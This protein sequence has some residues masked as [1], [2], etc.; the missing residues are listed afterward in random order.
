MEKERSGWKVSWQW[1]E[2]PP[3]HT[4]LL[5]HVRQHQKTYLIP[6]LI[7]VSCRF[8][9]DKRMWQ[10]IASYRLADR[11]T[12]LVQDSIIT[13]FDTVVCNS[14]RHPQ[15]TWAVNVAL[16]QH[17]PQRC[18]SL[19]AEQFFKWQDWSSDKTF[20]ESKGITSFRCKA[21]EARRSCY[22]SFPLCSRPAT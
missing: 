9:Q 6:E 17:E 1:K 21:S 22:A 16:L 10:G 18:W 12:P 5:L 14:S 3:P 15:V 19:T 8:G 4:E 20:S 2:R 13:A 11:R 7:R